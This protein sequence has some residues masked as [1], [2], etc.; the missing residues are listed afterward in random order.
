MF[1]EEKAQKVIK[2]ILKKRKNQNFESEWENT[3]IEKAKETSILESRL[4]SN[5]VD[6]LKICRNLSSHPSIENSE[7]KLITPD[8]YETAHFM[9]V[10]FKELFMM[11]PTFLGSVTS[12]FID[13]I[14]DKKKIFMN[15]KSK[16]KLY[17]E[18]NFLSNMK[19]TQIQHLAKDLF[20]FIFI[21]NNEDC[22]ENR[23]IN[24]AA[25]TIITKENKDLVIQEIMSDADLLKQIR[26]DDIEVRD[27]LELFVIENTKLWDNL[28]DLQKNEINDDSESS[29]KNYYRNTLIYSDETF[30]DRIRETVENYKKEIFVG[31]TTFD[32]DDKTL[33]L[34]TRKAKE[35]GIMNLFHEFCIIL[36]GKSNSFAD[37]G[38]RYNLLIRTNIE[39]FS[40]GNLE[41]LMSVINTNCQIY[42]SFSVDKYSIKKIYLRNFTDKTEEDI[43]KRYPY[44]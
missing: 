38:K 10:L 2:E 6:E 18:E 28:T 43:S 3:L 44:F 42:Q 1:E 15:D 4:L 37:A 20:K 24:Y 32:L 27:L 41:L 30:V 16:L 31:P 8:K 34:L 25:L 26:I 29:L 5:T 23:D 17:I 13:S 14:R 39:E 40:K 36:F 7:A 9:N 12:D 19:N 21:K 11:P 35:N 22:L 33:L